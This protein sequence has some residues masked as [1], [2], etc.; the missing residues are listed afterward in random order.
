[1]GSGHPGP[2]GPRRLFGDSRRPQSG[3]VVQGHGG[4]LLRGRTGWRR[5][6]GRGKKRS[7][8]RQGRPPAR[9]RK[10][11]PQ[12]GLGARAS[13]ANTGRAAPE[14]R[15]GLG[16]RHRSAPLFY[17]D[18]HPPGRAGEPP[19]D[20]GQG[21]TGRSQFPRG[22]GTRGPGARGPGPGCAPH[23]SERATTASGL[24][25]RGGGSLPGRTGPTTAA[26]RL[27]PA[28]RWRSPGQRPGGHRSGDLLHGDRLVRRRGTGQPR[29][30]VP[31]SAN[32]QG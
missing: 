5:L 18:H 26:G 28:R 3:R 21:A 25:G 29:G 2:G 19:G 12:P 13:Q 17:R 7:C 24:A 9:R 27:G 31:G 8:R 22:P 4:I 30:G 14:R 15:R 11:V 16:C 1:M 23:L 10:T 6:Q 20:Y 32:V